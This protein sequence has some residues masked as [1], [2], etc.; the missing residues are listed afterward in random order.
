MSGLP[1]LGKPAALGKYELEGFMARS[2]GADRTSN[3]YD[4]RSHRIAD[5][6]TT[7]P[8]A[9]AAWWYGWDA[10]STQLA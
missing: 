1:A 8:E 3:P 5:S 2:G 6:T 10:A 9:A 4:A 7:H